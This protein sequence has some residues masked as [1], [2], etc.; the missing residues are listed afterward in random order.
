[1]RTPGANFAAKRRRRW[2]APRIVR[3][4]LKELRET[5]RDRRTIATLLLM[6][7]LVYPLLSV[8]FERFLLSNMKPVAGHSDYVLGVRTQPEA[9]KL[10]RYISAGTLVLNA[11]QRRSALRLQKLQPSRTDQPP[12]KTPPAKD[13]PTDPP[14]D[15]SP[16][17]PVLY[18]LVGNSRQSVLDGRVDLGVEI[19]KTE[20]FLHGGG[21]DRAIDC[22]LFYDPQSPTSRDALHWMEGC[23]NAVNEQSLEHQLRVRGVRSRV[24]PVRVLSRSVEADAETNRRNGSPSLAT[25][26]PLILILMTITGAVYPAIDLTAGERERGTLETLIASPVP[27][28]QLLLAKYVA[29]LTV[30]LL[31]AVVNLAAMIGTVSS[32]GLGTVLFGEAGVS[33]KVL[34]EIVALLVLFAA[35]FSAVLLAVTSFARSFKEAQAYL[36]PL[37]L[38]SITPGMLSMIPGLKLQGPLVVT[39]LLNIVLLARDL[40]EPTGNVE[41]ATAFWVVISTALF[42]VAAI[43]VAARIFGTDA[44]LYGSHGT[45]SDLFHRPYRPSSAP[46]PTSA[47][48]CLAIMF[49]AYFLASNLLARSGMVSIEGRLILASLVTVLVF[50][51]LPLATAVLNRV[52]LAS[53]FQLRAA[54]PLV[55]AGAAVLGFSLWPFA[56][57]TLVFLNRWELVTFDPR[58]MEAARQLVEKIRGISP[59]VVVGALAVVPAVCEEF[60]FRG[61]LMSAFQRSMSGARAVILSSVLFGLFHLVAIE[62]LHFERLVPS[63][64][65]GLVLGWVCLRSG[66]ALPGMLLH[67]SHNS[68]LLLA[69]YYQKE[70]AAWGWGL[71]QSANIETAGLPASW[72]VAAA[73]GAAVGFAL[74]A[75]A[76]RRRANGLS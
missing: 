42:A 72:L 39:P 51:Q 20:P 43:G 70:L 64:C 69:A 67:A 23:L 54:G 32:I 6:P 2:A 7:I 18:E 31:T 53:G 58:T 11:R 48:L 24:V 38:V 22:D 34:L 16:P 45:W 63:T 57:E 66:S 26:V 19:N 40:L 28:M 44:I 75:L 30:A 15:A 47:L 12:A 37:M 36:I 60:F 25:L 50:L 3:L 21:V 56:H 14:A 76:T 74:V 52:D 35:F 61:F 29:V 55:F 10:G 68:L 73:I 4:A 33:L 59:F 9:D 13:M 65:L 5:L 17:I 27:R 1:L 71:D 46:T 8:A 49:P 41:P 62:Q